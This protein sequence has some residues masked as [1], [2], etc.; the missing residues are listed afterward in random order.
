MKCGYKI[1]RT[2]K[3][4]VSDTTPIGLDGKLKE[5]SRD[6][7]QT[8]TCV[9]VPR[10]VDESRGALLTT[11]SFFFFVNAFCFTGGFSSV[12]AAW[13][14]GGCAARL[15]FCSLANHKRDWARCKVFFPG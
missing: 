13:G 9:V 7:R 14:R 10:H 4:G 3:R 5:S 8:E 2:R 11:C 1:H 12:L 6:T 15:S